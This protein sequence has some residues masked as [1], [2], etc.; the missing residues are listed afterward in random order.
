MG[1]SKEVKT[2][3]MRILDQMKIGYKAYTYECEEFVDAVQIADMLGLSHEKVYKTLVTVGSKGEH[4]VFVIP[5][6]EELD[7]KKAAKAVGEKALSMI[8]VKEL[9]NRPG[10][11]MTVTYLSSLSLSQTLEVVFMAIVAM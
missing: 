2:N 10:I 7:L 8:P 3:V 1:K 9:L 11:P 4:F 6:R 5:I